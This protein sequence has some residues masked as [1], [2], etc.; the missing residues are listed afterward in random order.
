M[1]TQQKMIRIFSAAVVTVFVLMNVSCAQNTKK[2]IK[3][4]LAN[5]KDS[6][7]FALGAQIG[8]SIKKDGFDSLLVTSLFLA[9]I[10][11]GM[12]G[13]VKMTDE[14][15]MAVIKNYLDKEMEKQT[16]GLKEKGEK[17]LAENKSKPGVKTTASGL[18]YEVISEGGGAKPTATSTVKVHYTGTLTGGDVFDSSEGMDPVEFPLDRVIPGWT[19]GIQ[20]MSVGS[21]YKFYIPS[22]LAYGAEG[23]P[24]GGIGPHE[25]LIFEVE[26]LGVK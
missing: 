22:D 17:F 7:S 16:A 9:G 1:K 14:E 11:N 12:L 8:S 13:E 23:Q 10:Q 6:A 24:Q 4:K 2:P 26:L 21:K 20:L 25:V 18:Q 19:E 3:V 15:K 5:E